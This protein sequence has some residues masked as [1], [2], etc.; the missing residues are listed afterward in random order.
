MRRSIPLWTAIILCFALADPGRAAGLDPARSPDLL[1]Y[2]SFDTACCKDLKPVSTPYT[3]LGK[4]GRYP[5]ADYARGRTWPLTERNVLIDPK[6]RFGQAMRLRAGLPGYPASHG[7][8]C[9]FEAKRNVNVRR[10]TLAYWFKTNK[11]WRRTV[12]SHRRFLFWIGQQT[13]PRRASALCVRNYAKRCRMI[14]RD[15]DNVRSYG[16]YKRYFDFQVEPVV[17]GEWMHL[18]FVWDCERGMKAYRN[19][20]LVGSLWDKG[21][22]SQW[23]PDYS[24]DSLCLGNR[25]HGARHEP[26]YFDASYDE[27]YVFDRVLTDAEVRR[28][29]EENLPPTAPATGGGDPERFRRHRLAEV[30]LLE[31]DDLPVVRRGAAKAFRVSDI[32]V[33]SAMATKRDV[34]HPVDGKAVTVWPLIYQGYSVG[35][36]KRLILDLGRRRR[37]NLARLTG[38]ID[39][40]LTRDGR[41]VGTLKPGKPYNC[42]TRRIAFPEKPTRHLTVHRNSGQVCD[43][44]LYD[45]QPDVGELTTEAKADLLLS[46]KAPVS[47]PQDI[48]T[49][50]LCDFDPADRRVVT[51]RTKATP[52]NVAVPAL[53][54]WH[55]LLPAF[56][57][58][59]AVAGIT[60]DL[61]F[62]GAE[63]RL[64]AVKIMDPVTRLRRIFDFDFRTEGRGRLRLCLDAQDFMVR[65]GKQ[66]LLTL[67]CDKPISLRSG[68]GGSRVTVHFTT[69]RKALEEYYP[70]QLL[71]AANVLSAIIE[72]SPGK[73]RQGV[74]YYCHRG[75]AE[76]LDLCNDLYHYAPRYELYGVIDYA[77]RCRLSYDWAAAPGYIPP[78]P[79]KPV[80]ED[81]E[82][83]EWANYVRLAHGLTRRVLDWWID[84][85]Q[86][87]HGELGGDWDDDTDFMPFWAP[88]AMLDDDNGKVRDSYRR[89]ADW[90]RREHMNNGLNKRA[91]DD[92]HAYEDGPN[93][94]ARLA[95]MFYGEPEVVERL[96]DTSRRYHGYLLAKNPRGQTFFRSWRYGDGRIFT[97]GI[98]GYDVLSCLILEPGMYL[99]WYNHN[100]KN[101]RLFKDWMDSWMALA[102]P[103]KPGQLWKRAIRWETGRPDPPAKRVHASNVMFMCYRLIERHKDP[104]YFLPFEA[105]RFHTKK[106]FHGQNYVC[107]RK[108]LREV[109]P[110]KRLAAWDKAYREFW[111]RVAK[112]RHGVISRQLRRLGEPGPAEAGNPD[113]DFLDW[114]VTGD[115]R[116]AVAI[117]KRYCERMKLRYPAMTWVSASP[118]RI[119]PNP[120]PL[121]I[122]SLGGPVGIPKHWLYP[123]LGV[124]WRGGG[125][126]V[127]RLVVD[128][129]SNRLHVLLYNFDDKPKRISFRPWRLRHGDY[130]IVEGPDGNG[131]DRADRGS[132]RR[133]ERLWKAKPVRVTLPPR[134]T[135]VVACRLVKEYDAVEDRCD[136]GIGPNDLTYDAGTDTLSVKVHSLGSRPTP[137]TTLAVTDE[138][139]RS[140]VTEAV[141]ALKSTVDLT[142]ATVTLRLK[143]LKAKGA[144]RVRV[145]VDPD[146]KVPEITDGNNVQDFTLP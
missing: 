144:R 27:A 107:L 76:V 109:T 94:Q 133:V 104:R 53:R 74:P 45:L 116:Y 100:P 2:A 22:A 96:M 6:G 38:D 140:V 63:T 126:Q 8:H 125:Q 112:D 23:F 15:R 69:K 31:A 65:K 86:V 32:F 136:L 13:W 44:W 66:V 47:L 14:A 19:G 113:A 110:P 128:D 72:N 24:V 51:A 71:V 33:K 106:P 52:G 48:E 40:R 49:S 131:D 145:F 60:L 41:D 10:G 56:A 34:R 98:L 143:G 90:C 20:K 124:S 127:A 7:G 101:E 132:A 84:T 58:D 50:L 16:P 4:K 43:C 67:I 97:K 30:G 3:K 46:P 75:L 119:N 87:D 54:Y 129:W 79:F 59:K 85:R 83:P 26:S 99:T 39:G 93:M 95:L 80:F 91:T 135:W 5:N 42:V 81:K 57:E 139:G 114:Q 134:R 36:G 121:S 62:D 78:P 28:L 61:D 21:A 77:C 73:V 55:V 37:V 11:D 12:P 70:N 130:E 25:K 120:G 88:M 111:K 9:A 89:F 29:Y 137:A 92:V 64:W 103:R 122:L 102:D 138:R 35:G 17:D 142:P 118:D 146:G 115:K 68:P 82:A 18:A 141:P 1:F 123:M 117:L 105:K 108:V